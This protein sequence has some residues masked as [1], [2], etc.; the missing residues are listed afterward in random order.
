MTNIGSNVFSGT[1]YWNRIS[2]GVIYN[3][4]YL[5]G[6]KDKVPS[7]LI[8]EEGTKLIA[9]EALFQAKNL[10]S[11]TCSSELNYIGKSAFES[12]ENLE[13]ITFNENLKIIEA[14]CFSDCKKIKSVSFKNN[15]NTIGRNAFRGCN[16]LESIHLPDGIKSIGSNA[17]AD[18]SYWKHC[19]DNI[20][21][22]NSYLLGCK[23][24]IELSAFFILNNN[25]KNLLYCYSPFMER[26]LDNSTPSL[27][28]FS[29]QCRLISRN[30]IFPAL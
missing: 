15:L 28:S 18:T 3:N 20:I 12:C 17:F 4:N 10:I 8:V 1:K 11:I 24:I 6:Y 26:R 19:S 9:D 7:H 29:N 16:Q 5:L 30:E 13:S 22:I 14:N 25:I 21:Y 27:M 2:D 23:T